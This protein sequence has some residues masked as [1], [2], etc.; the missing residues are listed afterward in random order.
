MKNPASEVEI[1][2]ALEARPSALKSVYL[3][4]L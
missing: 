2:V 3:L 1:S 4:S